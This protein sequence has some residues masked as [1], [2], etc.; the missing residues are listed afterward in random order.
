MS[1]STQRLLLQ[2]KLLDQEGM[3]AEPILPALLATTIAS[4]HLASPNWS[5]SHFY[6]SSIHYSSCSK[7]SLDAS[8]HAF[9]DDKRHHL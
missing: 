7:R 1:N 3:G 5:D 2:P 6:T 4:L 9:N 8:V